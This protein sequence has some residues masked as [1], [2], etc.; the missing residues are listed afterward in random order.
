[1]GD[2]QRLPPARDESLGG[3]RSG[4][5][6]ERELV[7]RRERAQ[8]EHRVAQLGRRLPERVDPA[9]AMRDDGGYTA[10]SAGAHVRVD[11]LNEVSEYGDE[12]QISLTYAS[13]VA[14]GHESA[15]EHFVA[16]HRERFDRDEERMTIVAVDGRCESGCNLVDELGCISLR[17]HAR[18]AE[19]DE[20]KQTKHLEDPLVATH[21][22]LSK[23]TVRERAP[24]GTCRRG[25]GCRCGRYPVSFARIAKPAYHAHLFDAGTVSTCGC[26][27]KSP[28]PS[29]YAGH[30]L[31]FL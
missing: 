15:G 18:G 16:Q 10:N 12:L 23:G 7:D 26:K 24:L 22:V 17:E 19:D 5:Q 13:Q 20:G 25:R 2:S 9:H 27:L 4:R 28:R 31:F 1:M 6:R 14:K 3:G 29:A 30:H 8:S 11:S 21:S